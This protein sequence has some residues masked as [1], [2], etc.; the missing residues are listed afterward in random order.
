MD[1]SELEMKILGYLQNSLSDEDRK[2]VEKLILESPEFATEFE[3]V[4]AFWEHLDILKTVEPSPKIQA[5]FDAMLTEFKQQNRQKVTLKIGNWQRWAVAASILVVGVLGGMFFQKSVQN[6]K[7]DVAALSEE[8]HELKEMM[9]LTMLENPTATERMKAV[10]YTQELPKVNDKVLEALFTTLN[11]DEN[12]N[13]RL[14]TLDALVE[15]GANPIVREGLVAS[16]LK[17]ESPLMQVAMAD[18]LVQLQEK[19]SVKSFKKLLENKQLNSGVKQ[20]LEQSVKKLQ[21]I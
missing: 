20:K 12:E 1:N 4:K 14:V 11:T 2:K 21:I 8:V 10:S 5:N 15:L 18:A 19:K 9:M 6:P 13:V 7:T 16:L 17:Q 3:E